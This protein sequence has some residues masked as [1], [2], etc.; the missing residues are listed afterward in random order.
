MKLIKY[1]SSSTV[2]SVWVMSRHAKNRIETKQ[3]LLL[4]SPF[5]TPS[6]SPLQILLFTWTLYNNPF[7]L[8]DLRFLIAAT[9]DLKG[10]QLFSIAI[11][12]THTHQPG[13]LVEEQ[14]ETHYTA[15]ST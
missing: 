14:C 9:T 7:L 13:L 12:G 5:Y 1:S 8:K 3:F 11:Q 2:I 15:S 6:D 4:S 10:M